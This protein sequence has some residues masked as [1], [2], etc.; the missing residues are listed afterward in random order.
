MMLLYHVIPNAMGFWGSQFWD[1][2]M[3]MVTMVTMAGHSRIHPSVPS[4][5]AAAPG[6][7]LE[8]LR[9]QSGTP[10]RHCS[11]W[12]HQWHEFV[13]S[14]RHPWGHLRAQWIHSGA[15][16]G[17]KAWFGKL[18]PVCWPVLSTLCHSF[19]NLETLR[20]E[21]QW[22]TMKYNEWMDMNGFFPPVSQ[23]DIHALKG[24]LPSHSTVPWSCHRTAGG[25]S[26]SWDH[27]TNI[28]M[29][30]PRFHHLQGMVES[31]PTPQLWR[32]VLLYGGYP[33]RPWVSIL[34]WFNYSAR[35]L[36]DLGVPQF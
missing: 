11:S 3:S 6:L 34:K 30:S 28:R 14:C 31:A 36:D 4:P 1:I 23:H 15:G 13:S 32:A 25:C 19:D 18:E 16:W 12:T 22:N 17:A 5:R 33:W 26:R 7:S 20:R 24:Q 29:D 21:I 27:S 2:H 8:R 9:C 35:L 10:S